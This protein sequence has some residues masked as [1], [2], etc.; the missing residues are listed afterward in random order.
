LINNDKKGKLDSYD[1]ESI[2]RVLLDHTLLKVNKAYWRS[3][4][5]N[6]PGGNQVKDIVVDSIGAVY[7]GERNWNPE[8]EP[9]I[10]EYLKGVVDSKVSHLLERYDHKHQQY[11]LGGGDTSVTTAED[12]P[13]P[14]L[15]DVGQNPLSEAIAQDW[16]NRLWKA[17]G[18]DED[19]QFVLICFEEGVTDR[20]GLAEKLGWE[21]IRVDNTLK[22]IRR[23]MKKCIESK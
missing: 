12:S 9:D 16:W 21:V 10:V 17:S 22:R 4:R 3:G 8:D 13:I 19:M 23:H 5:A 20:S 15:E 7:L 11:K 1:W 2:S 18:D 6:L 14:D